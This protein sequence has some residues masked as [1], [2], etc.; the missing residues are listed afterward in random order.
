MHGRLLIAGGVV[1]A[2]TVLFVAA[3][4]A[5]GYGQLHSTGLYNVP[6]E[7]VDLFKLILGSAIAVLTLSTLRLARSDDAQNENNDE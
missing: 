5:N 6:P 3:Y 7:L 1:F 4:I 2:A